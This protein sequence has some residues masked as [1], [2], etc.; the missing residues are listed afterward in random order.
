MSKLIIS[1]KSLKEV[2]YYTYNLANKIGKRFV[3]M[4]QNDSRVARIFFGGGGGDLAGP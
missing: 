1:T 4:N 3:E 2:E